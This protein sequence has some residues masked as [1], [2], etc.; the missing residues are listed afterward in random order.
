MAKLIVVGGGLSGCEA[1]WQAAIRGIQVDLYEM[2]PGSMTGAHR[3]EQLAEIVCSN[4]LGSN[5]IDR[6]AGLLKEE[7]SR[8]GSLLVRCAEA[9]A[10]PA[11]RALAVDR[12]AFA[13]LVTDKITSHPKI[14]LIRREVPSIPDQ[15]AVIATGPLTSPSLSVSLAGLT[16]QDHLYFY[17]AIAPTVQ[18]SSIDMGKAF[19][20]SR[21]GYEHGEMDD[22]GDYINCPLD[23]AEYR[24]FVEELLKAERIELHAFEKDIEQGVRAGNSHFFE[25]CLPVEIIAQRGIDALAFG[26]MRPVGLKNPHAGRRPYAILQLR[27]DNIAGTL[28]NLVGFQTNLKYEEQKRIFRMIPG[29]ETAEFTRFGQMHRNTFIFSPAL[30]ESTMQ[31]RS[32]SDLFLAGQITGVEGYMGNIATG[33]L[34]GINAAH[35]LLGVPLLEMPVTTML[36]ALCR[37][38]T[39]AAREDFQPMKANFGLFQ[40]LDGEPIR[41]RRLRAQAHAERALTELQ[42]V[43]PGIL[44]YSVQWNGLS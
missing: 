8:M 33:L 13:R 5:L 37:Y 26:P 1:A 15:P 16:G 17:D 28:Y 10:I 19:R 4:S 14:K 21:Y 34:A 6:P 36:G 9:T 11:G 40:P 12:E 42:P 7:I 38:I 31:F 3:S 24:A 18:F 43:L 20:A 30:L 39:T 32:R 29:L 23:Q 27:Q 41:S 35:F 22:E 2:R 44:N 25:S